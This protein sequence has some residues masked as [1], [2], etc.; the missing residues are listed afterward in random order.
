MQCVRDKIGSVPESSFKELKSLDFLVTMDFAHH[1]DGN[2][3]ARG[4]TVVDASV[5]DVAAWEMCKSSRS[6][7]KKHSA[8]GGLERAYN[9]TNDHSSIYHVVYDLKLPGLTPREWVVAQIWKWKNSSSLEVFVFS[10]NLGDFPTRVEYTRAS[11]LVLIT[12]DRL[13]EAHGTPLTRVTLKQ[14]VDLKGSIPKAAASGIA[15]KE[16]MS[17][18]K[19]RS[20]FDRSA[21]ID[22]LSRRAIAAEIM[23]D[24]EVYTQEENDILQE[25]LGHFDLFVTQKP[26]KIVMTSPLTSALVARTAGDNSGWGLSTTIVRGSPEDIMAFLW[27]TLCR[28]KRN[29]DDLEK[30][31]DETVNGHNQVIYQKKKTPLIIDNRDFVGRCVWKKTSEGCYVFVSKPTESVKRPHLDG[32]VRGLYPS[33]MKVTR[34]DTNNTRVDYV[35]HPNPGGGV[36]FW[37]ANAWLSSALRK[38]TDVQ[39]TFQNFRELHQWDTD[40]GVAVGEAMVI[41]TKAEKHHEKGETVVQ[42]R[43]RELFKK[44]SG[45]KDVQK[46]YIFFEAMMVRVVRNKLRPAYAMDAGL[47]NVSLKGG[48]VI[49]AGLSASL[50]SNL[51]AQTAVDEWI[52][53]YPA[54]KEIDEKEIWFR[55]MMNTV[56]VR[57]LGAVS[58][59]LKMRVLVGAG[60]SILDVGSDVNVIFL[61]LRTEG[62]ED[63]AFLLIA[64]LLTGIFFHVLLVLT[65]H[66]SNKW[67]MLK[68]AL[69]AVVGL[70]P[71]ADAFRVSSGAEIQEGHFIDPSTEL[72]VSKGIELFSEGIPGKA[73]VGDI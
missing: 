66:K 22:A 60:L 3:V 63:Y 7:W 8:F 70:K 18:S 40:D 2:G 44:N 32:V 46:K 25:G 47:C 26:K 43:L 29:H 11:S 51:T 61:Y 28:A 71:V 12:Y 20:H 31:V 1:G 13:E 27:D 21:E 4:S 24:D 15:Q 45:L 23:R 35:I 33:T 69:V 30:A 72:V 54:L 48:T 16:M 55:P 34:L 73:R 68:E 57:L 67:T 50:A 59:G 56:A 5:D 17:L 58:W 41:K 19:M 52:L 42:A 64:M 14:S 39:E 65:Q 6:A 38:V 10:V 36:P 9:K 62:Q 37:L 53:K 49:G